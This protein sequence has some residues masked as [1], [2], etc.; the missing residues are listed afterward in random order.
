MRVLYLIDQKVEEGKTSGIITKVHGQIS[1]WNSLGVAV[2]LLS[3]YDFKK[4]DQD[5]KCIDESLS[6]KLKKH[7]R[8][9]TL[10]RMFI[11]TLRL[12]SYLKRQNTYD[13]I[14]TRQRPWMPFQ[15]KILKR[16]PTII[17]INT[18][19]QEEYKVISCVMFWVNKF[20]RIWFYP[21]A[22]GFVGVTKE[23]ASTY[24]REFDIPSIAIGNGIKTANYKVNY[25][26]NKRPQVVFIGAPGF[27]W[28]GLEKFKF[29]AENLDNVDFHVIGIE[30]KNA[31]NITYYGY[32]K[33]SEAKRIIGQCDVG[34]SSL[35]LYINS[36]K[37]SGPL[38]ARQYFAQGIPTIYAYDDTDID[39]QYDFTLKLPN[40]E[41]N[42][43]K[44]LLEIEKFI[45]FAHG[46]K[47]LRDK[48]R[49]YAER[50]FD[51][52]AK[53]EIRVSFF[54]KI[55]DQNH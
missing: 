24:S 48:T 39:G 32:Q 34:I 19:D 45:F 20:T 49:E 18:F 31:N 42:I 36:L 25:P 50:K 55:Y 33:L 28:H 1:E 41:D 22:K 46:N 11:S 16:C 10:L 53:E 21:Y 27:K 29:I 44:F 37:E 7:G 5:L 43:S 51:V 13:L 26:E 40:S 47:E 14:Y 35:S 8:F 15:K 17:E 4:Y 12:S 2:D 3:M 6:F 9:Y 54:K 30:G 38:K 23:L 52:K